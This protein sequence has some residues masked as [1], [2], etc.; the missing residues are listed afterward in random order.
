MKIYDILIV[1]AGPCGLACAIEAQQKGLSCL[2]VE[3]GS[4][5]ESIRNYPLQMRFFSTADN[6][7]I[8]EIPFAVAEAKASRV[9]ALQYYRKVAEY[10]Q[11]PLLLSTEVKTVKKEAAHFTIVTSNET[12]LA[13]KVVLAVGYFNC[14][15]KIEVKGEDLP[16]VKQY[17]DEPFAYV[18]TSVVIVGGGNSAVEAALDLYRHG[19]KVT[20][21]IRKQDFKPTA[22][23][24]L[25]PDLRNRV[26]EGNIAVNFESEVAE[27]TDKAVFFRQK[28]LSPLKSVEANTVFVLT[29]YT[30]DTSFLTACGIKVN[31]N[32]LVPAYNTDTFETNVE[33][34]YLAGTAICGIYTEKVFI[35]NGRHHGK[36]IVADILEKNAQKMEV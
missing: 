28:G 12:Y 22:K 11:L 26:K 1:G 27:I 13:K 23:Y 35:E 21:I 14:P 18:H 25:L 7:S 29:G 31:E 10:F 19:V 16:H 34:L 8:A 15:K 24:W 9:E 2:V 5:A 17:Y 30:T 36:A 6:I 3:K 32:D 20:M 4:I 33:G